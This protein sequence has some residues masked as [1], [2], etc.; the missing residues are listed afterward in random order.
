MAAEKSERTIREVVLRYY[1]EAQGIY[2]FGTYGTENEKPDSDIDIGL[3][4]PVE[5][6]K[7]EKNLGWS[8]CRFAIEDALQKEV[9]LLNAREVSTILQKEIV[10]RGTLIHAADQYAVDEFEMLVLSYYQKLNEERTGIIEEAV[11]S[12]RFYRV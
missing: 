6:A 1:P 10:Y 2:L 11:N 4:L 8:A 3:L 12:R 9:D 7:R 5:Q